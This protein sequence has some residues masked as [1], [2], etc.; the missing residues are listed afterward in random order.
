MFTHFTGQHHAG[1]ILYFMCK[2]HLSL[3][4]SSYRTARTI[5]SII[6]LLEVFPPGQHILFTHRKIACDLKLQTRNAARNASRLQSVITQLGR[7]HRGED[8]GRAA[9]SGTR[10]DLLTASIHKCAHFG[11]GMSENSPIYQQWLLPLIDTT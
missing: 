5:Q 4:P 6:T 9:A 7:K 10:C 11:G 2:H 1:A 8:V 3:P